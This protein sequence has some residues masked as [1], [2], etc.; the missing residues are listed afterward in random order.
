VLEFGVSDEPRGPGV[1]IS[2]DVSLEGVD[3]KVVLVK[4]HSVRALLYM[5]KGIPLGVIVVYLSNSHP[6]QV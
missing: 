5:L 1:V 3:P 2:V 6:R 4:R